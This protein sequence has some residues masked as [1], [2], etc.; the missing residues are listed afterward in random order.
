[1]TTDHR[2]LCAELLYAVQSHLLFTDVDTTTAQ[3]RAKRVDDAMNAARAAL[4]QP[5]PVP[6]SLLRTERRDGPWGEWSALIAQPV[7]APDQPEPVGPTD[8]ELYDLA[9]EYDGE[10][11]Q[12]MRAALARWGRPAIAPIPVSER[13]P[14]A[15]D[16][17]AEGQCWWWHPETDERVACWCYSRGNGTERHWLN[18]T[19]L[20]L[21]PSDRRPSAD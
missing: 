13:L 18:A 8:E 7:P 11:V 15:D 20:P 21:P 6:P 10:P 16:C 5:E 1:M 14:E 12:S 17:D 9:A 2:A 19:A 4:A 3:Q